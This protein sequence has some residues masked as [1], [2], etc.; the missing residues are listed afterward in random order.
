M[1]IQEVEGFVLNYQKGCKNMDLVT[2]EEMKR[3]DDYTC[4]NRISAKDLVFIAGSNI[5]KRIMND[6]D[7]N[8]VLVLCG[9]SG[10]GADAFVVAKILKDNGYMVDAYSISNHYSELC[11]YY[12]NLYDGNIIDEIKDT[13]YDLIVDG[14][15]GIGLSKELKENYISL[16]NKIN[17]TKIKIVSIDIPSGID[18]SFGISYGTFIKADKCY[19]V[20]YAKTGLFL[21]DGLDSYKEL[22]V[23]P[24]GI[25]KTN[26]IIHLNEKNDFKHSFKER[27]SNTNKGSYHKTA[28]VAGSY[29]YAGASYISYMALSSLMMGIG[30]SYLY[31][32]NCIYDA[33]LLKEPEI[34]LSKLSSIDGHIS[35]NEKELESLLKMDSISIGMGMDISYDLYLT[36]DYLLKHYEG[37]LVIDADGINTLAKYG[38]DILKNKKCEVILTPHLKEMERLSKYSVD[39]IKRNPFEIVKEFTNEYQVCLI[40]KSASSII[41]NGEYLNISAFGNTA[42]AK[43]GSGDMLS[44]ILSG[45]LAYLDYDTL[46]ISNMACYILGRAAEFASLKK[47]VECILPKD[48]IENIDLVIKEIKN[49]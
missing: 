11:E 36:I 10:N 47:E 33:F 14:L 4:L 41:S 48:V 17:D 38:L 30:Y 16:I 43:G 5:A 27:L 23:I 25:E 34:L 13:D 15:I 40:L 22:E 31:V 46:R 45:L 12:K 39:E 42:L 8:K 28:I 7:F 21:Q 20:E 3:I 35:F 9:S 2:K 29:K 26:N 49:D 44:G 19:T 6:Y 32:P 1:E 24:V 18:A 37:R